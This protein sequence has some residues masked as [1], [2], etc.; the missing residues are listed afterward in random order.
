MNVNTT[1][2]NSTVKGKAIPLQAWSGTEVSRKLKSPDFTTTH[3]MVVRLSALCTGRLYPQEIHL[4]LIS[5]KRL[6]GPQGHSATGRIMSLKN[7][8]DSTVQYLSIIRVKM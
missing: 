4:V 2:H 7:S 8:S 6:S 5:V 3:R 1:D